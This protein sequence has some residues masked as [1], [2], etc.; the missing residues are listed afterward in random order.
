MQSI[1]HQLVWATLTVTTLRVPYPKYLLVSPTFATFRFGL[2]WSQV[3]WCIWCGNCSLHEPSQAFQRVTR[4]V[5]SLSV[6]R[7]N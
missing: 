2:V 5:E 7:T 6:P 4:Q 1:N 3:V